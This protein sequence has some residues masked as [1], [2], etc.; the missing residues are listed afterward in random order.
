[1]FVATLLCFLAS[2]SLV[3]SEA[4]ELTG[5]PTVDADSLRESLQQVERR[6]AELTESPEKLQQTLSASPMIQQLAKREPQVAADL[7]DLKRLEKEMGILQNAH[8]E[9]KAKLK[10][11]EDPKLMAEAVS[12]TQEVIN[13][14]H[15]M[16]AKVMQEMQEAA[17]AAQSSFAEVEESPRK[18][19]LLE[20]L[21]PRTA[22]AFQAPGLSGATRSGVLRS[23]PAVMQEG[24]LNRKVVTFDYNGVFEGREK[25]IE[26]D[27]VK[28]LTRLNELRAL[29][30]IA[31][32]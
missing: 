13:N 31:D 3:L 23:D 1:M 25:S 26:K 2:G 6:L 24:R 14:M 7:K 8:E 5:V 20:M 28:P 4:P 10:A 22:E 19:P 9:V 12:R 17:G 18:A 30:T 16:Q 32:A 15:A 11:L 21:L 27:P 29:T